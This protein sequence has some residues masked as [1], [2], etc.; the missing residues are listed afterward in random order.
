MRKPTY[1]QVI[2]MIVAMPFALVAFVLIFSGILLKA[3]G[4][5]CVLDFT[6]AKREI[7]QMNSI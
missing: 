1:Q 5:L 6:A 7:E 2:R 4:C 3:A